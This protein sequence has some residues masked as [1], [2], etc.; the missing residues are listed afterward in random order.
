MNTRQQERKLADQNHPVRQL[1]DKSI[2]L[3]KGTLSFK[4]NR[5]ETCHSFYY[6]LQVHYTLDER[7]QTPPYYGWRSVYCMGEL[8]FTMLEPDQFIVMVTKDNNRFLQ[9][10]L[11]LPY[12]KVTSIDTSEDE[13]QVIVL[14]TIIDIDALLEQSIPTTIEL[15]RS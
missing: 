13:K 9:L 3:E 15:Y 7:P 4:D 6:G 12:F 1:I 2:K 10:L 14:F 8:D 5:I 11:S